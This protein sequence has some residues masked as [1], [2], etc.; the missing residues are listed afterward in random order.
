MPDTRDGIEIV[1]ESAL[2]VNS[3]AGFNARLA[4][5]VAGEEGVSDEA[6]AAI[7]RLA[8]T[9]ADVQSGLTYGEESHPRDEHGRFI[10][11][12]EPVAETV[13][14][15]GAAPAD[16]ER[17]PEEEDP[18]AVQ[19]REAEK[20]IGRQGNELGELRQA[21]Q[22]ERE[23]RL[24]L[25][26][27]VEATPAAAPVQF[28]R[29]QLEERISGPN[30]DGSGGESAWAWAANVGDRD[31]LETVAEI[32]GEYQPFHAARRWND[33]ER[34]L[35]EYEREAQAPEAP[36][37]D[38]RLQQI[39]AERQF[40][41]A[42]SAA[43]TEVGLADEAQWNV[44]REHVEEALT[45]ARPRVLKMI[46]SS[47]P[48]EQQE[49]I[50]IILDTAKSR[51]IAQGVKQVADEVQAEKVVAKK[52]A[53]IATGSLRPAKERQPASPEVTR[54]EALKRFKTSILEAETAS[55]ADGLTYG[56]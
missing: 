49:G 37:P 35:A 45:S 54:E 1:E 5:K 19:Y 30:G 2:D 12:E 40:G 39:V 7:A 52:A 53:S 36:A 55:V 10:P 34:Y 13:E 50:E 23:A 25:E 29:E 27:R 16:E 22:E 56:S 38:P 31:L 26:G 15:E 11:K 8:E 48:Q 41:E 20:L 42:F 46:D 17:E 21:L 28:D 44:V 14:E 4:A 51:A 18:W 3:D 6:K 43:R 33:F 24:K 32:W 9:D 47:D